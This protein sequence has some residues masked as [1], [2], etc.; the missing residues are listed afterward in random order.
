MGGMKPKFEN[1]E[2]KGFGIYTP[3]TSS[4]KSHGTCSCPDLSVPK[5]LAGF[6]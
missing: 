6:L 1:A 4:L 5:S 3:N 2:E